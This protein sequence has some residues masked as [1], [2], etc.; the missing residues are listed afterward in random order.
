MRKFIRK[1]LIIAL[2]LSPAAAFAQSYRPP[3]NGNVTLPTNGS[4]DRFQM[5]ALQVA[6]CS[7]L[8]DPGN[9]GNIYFGGNTVTNATG[10]NKGMTLQPGVGIFD[11]TL[12]NLSAAY[13][14]TATNNNKVQWTC[15]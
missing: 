2:V 8:A 15:N 7:F 5:P 3:V 9:V 6:G 1:L 12:T 13:F 11:V 10:S 14:S 4:T